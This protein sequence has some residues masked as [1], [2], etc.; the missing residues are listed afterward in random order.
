MNFKLIFGILATVLGIISFWPY[1]KD[2]LHKKTKP[3]VYSWL[4]WTIIQTVGVLAMIKGGASF[5]AL[6]LAVGTLFCITIFLLAF[7]YGTRNITKLDTFLLISALII[8]VFWLI[9]KDPLISVILVTIIDTIAF[10]PTYR[11]TYLAPYTETLSA[12]Y[13]L[14]SANLLSIFAIADYSL[15]TTL[16]IS[17][18]VVTDTIMIFLLIFRR[19]VILR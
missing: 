17:T 9:Q 18:L 8:I 16:Y 11:K 2:I 12:Y 14:A 13:L 5:G 10:M 4:V 15:T 3:H 19:N 7:K 1:L 6:G